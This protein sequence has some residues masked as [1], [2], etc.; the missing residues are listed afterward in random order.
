MSKSE[1]DEKILSLLR[2]ALGK[3][4]IDPARYLIGKWG[5]ERRVHDNLCLLDVGNGKWSV[6]YTE[7]GIIS[8]LSYHSSL[9][10]AARDIFIRLTGAKLHWVFREAWEKET[11]QVF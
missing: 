9:D 3:E 7:R 8:R 2:F 4:G 11:G 5:D 6:L 1:Y 10:D